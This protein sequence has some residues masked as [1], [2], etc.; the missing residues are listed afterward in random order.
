MITAK[1]AR[2]KTNSTE[3]ELD[4]YIEKVHFPYIEGEIERAI[5][6]TANSV[7]IDVTNIQLFTYDRYATNQRIITKL[8][9]LGYNDVKI[10]NM[11]DYDCSDSW[12]IL[13]FSW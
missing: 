10:E 3:V 7:R 12:Y 8:K 9:A 5:N 11:Q 2:N 4:N 13:T 1:E 6:S